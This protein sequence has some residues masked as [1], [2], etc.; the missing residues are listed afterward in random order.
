MVCFDTDCFKEFMQSKYFRSVYNLTDSDYKDII[1]D[2]L[3][4]LEFGYRLL[5]QVLFGE[6]TIP[7]IDQA[8]ETRRE[9]RKEILEAR[10][11]AEIAVHQ[12][13][14]GFEKYIQDKHRPSRAFLFSTG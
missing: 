12:S 8:F 1:D 4:R 2:K 13:K 5:R 9:D 10:R 3:K 14:E 11:K 6:E 7:L